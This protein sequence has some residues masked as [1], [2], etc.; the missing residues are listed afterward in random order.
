MPIFLR[1][2][3]KRKKNEEAVKGGVVRG[4]GCGCGGGWQW[5]G[6]EI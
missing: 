6:V 3:V 1:E 2:D 5:N 4:A